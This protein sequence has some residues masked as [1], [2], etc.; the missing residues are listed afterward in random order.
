MS[1]ILKGN[2]P[3]IPSMYS[4]DLRLLVSEM[5]DKNPQRRPSATSILQRKII[6][7]R[8]VSFL[9]AS[10]VEREGMGDWFERPAAAA[11]AA[12]A[13]LPPSLPPPIVPPP[14][15]VMLRPSAREP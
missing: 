8:I 2:Y 1:K 3:P 6:K 5:L 12:A 10:M 15:A 13:P 14:S 7:E 11:A 4:Q 9:S